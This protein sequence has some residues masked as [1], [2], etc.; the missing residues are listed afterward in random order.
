MTA[1]PL[2]R[3]KISDSIYFSSVVDARYKTN[4]ISIN[5]FIPLQKETVSANALIPFVLRKGCA[6]YPDFTQLNQKLYS[7]YGSY[8]DTDV[9]KSGDNQVIGLSITGIDNAYTL[10]GENIIKEMTDILFAILL[11]PCLPDGLFSEKELNLER[12]MLIDLIESEINEKRSY[13]IRRALETM[14]AGDPYGIDK[15]GT[16]E[17]VKSISQ[18][19]LTEAY[20]SLIRSASIEILFVGCGNPEIALQPKKLLLICLIYLPPGLPVRLFQDMDR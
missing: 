14:C 3:T 16:V 15:Y 13:A 18:K 17:Q 20:R 6:D 7:L 8:L 1:Y 2:N 12:Q 11:R 5:L 4:R 19:E 9:R 10:E